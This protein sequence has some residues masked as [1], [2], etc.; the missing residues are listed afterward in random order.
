MYH[1][2]ITLESIYDHAKSF[3]NKAKYMKEYYC[4][5]TLEVL[6]SYDT[7]VMAVVYH[8]IDEPRIFKLWD[9]YSP[10]TMRHINEYLSQNFADN[11]GGKKWWDSLPLSD[12]DQVQIDA[13]RL[14]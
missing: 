4:H 5:S 1:E 11:I 7:E 6:K 3:Y 9:G 10:T 2:I 12:M 14:W 8:E 13:I